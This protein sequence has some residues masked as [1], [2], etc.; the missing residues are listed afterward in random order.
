M[1][2]TDRDDVVSGARGALGPVGV[3]LP[4][5]FTGTPSVGLQ[6]EAVGR[7]ERAGYRAAWT[8]EVVGGKD[9]LVQVALLLAATRRMV[10]GTGIANIW[11]RQPATM[12]AAAA[13]LAEAYP[14]RFVLGLGVGH[15]QQAAA[16]GQVYGSPLATMR[17][18]RARMDDPTQPPAPDVRYPRIL[19]AN[20]PN[21]LALAGRITDGALPAGL[22]PEFTAQARQVLG[23]DKL[24]VAGVSVVVD[25]DHDRARALARERVS[26]SFGMPSYAAAIAGL[27]YED[28]GTAEPSDRLVDAVVGHGSAEAIAATVRRHLAAGA[29][30]VLLMLPPGGE[31]TAGVDQLVRIA[32]PLV[33]LG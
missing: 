18:Y 2:P 23:P 26:A 6:R 22:P 9:A 5:S 1:G 28:D 16:T 33:T 30:H 21:M 17:D 8:N 13:Q 20:G 11:A 4:V 25:P 31:F 29:D 19:G 7:L 24:L 3:L 10:F 12:H 15:P 14:H 32:G 27:G